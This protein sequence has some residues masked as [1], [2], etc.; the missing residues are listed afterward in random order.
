MDETCRDGGADAVTTRSGGMLADA[1]ARSRPRTARGGR[2]RRARPGCST[3][4]GSPSGSQAEL[5]R[6]VGDWDRDRAWQADKATSAA[7]WL[8]HHAGLSTAAASRIVQSARLDPRYATVERAL[9]AGDVTVTR[10]SDE[11]ARVERHRE[12]AVRAGRRCAGRGGG[13]APSPGRSRSIAPPLASPG[14]RRRVDRRGGAGLRAA[15]P[16]RVDHAR[17][18]GPHRRRARPRGRCAVSSPRWTGTPGRIRPTTRSGPGRWPSAAP[19]RSSISPDPSPY[20]SVTRERPR[21]AVEVLIDPDDAR[22]AGGHGRL[23]PRLRRHA[24]DGGP[25]SVET[26]A[27]A[28]VRL[29]GRRDRA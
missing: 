4:A 13:S 1:Q 24:S 12:R 19:T 11:L 5:V 27:V 10:R 2:V 14:R 16:L 29:D 22:G 28:A 8:C 17:R 26:G 23:G 20:R 21:P 9:A 15:Y 25:I 6:A 3:C 18:D 7:T